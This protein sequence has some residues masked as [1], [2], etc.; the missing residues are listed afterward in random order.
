MC[1]C[2]VVYVL[3]YIPMKTEGG[4]GVHGP[5]GPPLNLPLWLNG[6]CW[7]VTSGSVRRHTQSNQ[8]CI[9]LK[10]STRLRLLVEYS[11]YIQLRLL[12]EY[13]SFIQPWLDH[14]LSI[15]PLF[16]NPTRAGIWCL[17]KSKNLAVKCA[18][19]NGTL[20]MINQLFDLPTLTRRLSLCT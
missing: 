1:Y 3:L 9:K 16:G 5:P 2:R 4:R 6:R 7:W 20:A 19:N 8:G 11:I 14:I 17:K 10:K 15:P 12:V 18:Q 13:L